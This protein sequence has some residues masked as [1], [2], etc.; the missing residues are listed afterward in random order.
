M[1]KIIKKNIARPRMPPKC[2][3]DYRSVPMST[4]MLGIVLILLRGL[5]NLNVLKPD[6]FFIEGS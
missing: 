6:I 4:F 2:I 5:N 3:R 1:A